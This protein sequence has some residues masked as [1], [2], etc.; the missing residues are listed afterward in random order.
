[1]FS[2][3]LRLVYWLAY[4]RRF[5]DPA[6]RH[7][8]TG[9]ALAVLWR[10]LVSKSRLLSSSPFFISE[11]IL[12]HWIVHSYTLLGLFLLL[13]PFQMFSSQ[14]ASMDVSYWRCIRLW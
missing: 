5:S 2:L 11:T 1:M 8:L 10:C 7:S 3:Q 14:K 9:C 4:R 13:M 6:L 12:V